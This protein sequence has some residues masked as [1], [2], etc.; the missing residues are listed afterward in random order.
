MPL[1][2]CYSSRGQGFVLLSPCP[3]GA[4][5]MIENRCLW[6]GELSDEEE[7]VILRDLWHPGKSDSLARPKLAFCLYQSIVFY[8]LSHILLSLAFKALH[9]LTTAPI[10]HAFSIPAKHFPHDYMNK[11]LF[12]FPSS[13]YICCSFSQEVHPFL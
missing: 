2:R 6:M 11:T 1:L 10:C 5:H 4:W 13:L 12:H 9:H 7:V 8:P 3:F